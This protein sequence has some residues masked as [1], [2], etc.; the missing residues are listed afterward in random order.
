M[1]DPKKPTVAETP[2]QDVFEDRHPTAAEKQWAEKTLAP[3]LEKA[4]EKPIGT[5]TGTNLDDHGHAAGRNE[6]S[7]AR[8][9]QLGT[10]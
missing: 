10:R 3:T 7:G 4:P 1:A 5:P 6:C 9:I 2:I 8:V